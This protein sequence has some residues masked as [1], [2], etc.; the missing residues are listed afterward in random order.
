MVLASRFGGQRLGRAL[1]ARRVDGARV[2]ACGGQNRYG[3]NLFPS[4]PKRGA[5]TRHIIY[6]Y[7]TV[8]HR[9][10]GNGVENGRDASE[11]IKALDS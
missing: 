4:F 8:R 10:L 11:A 1:P 3:S 7:T 5:S 9:P 6:D 2:G